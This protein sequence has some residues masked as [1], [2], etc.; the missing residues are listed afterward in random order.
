MA[1]MSKQKKTSY[2]VTIGWMLGSIVLIGGYD[3]YAFVSG[4]TDATI[5]NVIIEWSYAYPI[6][7]FSLG[8]LF[9]LLAGHLFWQLPKTDHINQGE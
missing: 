4:G 9:G 7:T 6:F 5:S 8:F 1:E 3:I 2:I